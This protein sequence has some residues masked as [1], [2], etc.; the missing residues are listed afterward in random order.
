[1]GML[2]ECGEMGNLRLTNSGA[3]GCGK[4]ISDDCGGR[5][6]RGTGAHGRGGAFAHPTASYRALLCGKLTIGGAFLGTGC[7]IFTPSEQNEP[8]YS[9][10]AFFFRGIL[11]FLAVAVLDLTMKGI[12]NYY[13]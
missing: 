9:S 1:M 2:G 8:F 7:P 10:E 12:L 4:T 11:E 6:T 5:T 3:S 13:F